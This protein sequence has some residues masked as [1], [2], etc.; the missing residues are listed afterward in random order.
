MFFLLLYLIPYWTNPAQTAEY[1]IPGPRD[2]LTVSY[3]AVSPSFGALWVAKEA[4]M[5]DRNGLDVR[6]IFIQSSPTNIQALINNELPRAKSAGYQKSESWRSASL[7]LPWLRTY[8][9]TTSQPPR[10]PT[11]A[12]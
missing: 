5:F 7:G 11:V 8:L 3:S 12:T 10:S 6:L 9:S 1:A 4:G 2:Q